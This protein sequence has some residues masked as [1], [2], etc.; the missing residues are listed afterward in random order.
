MQQ[1]EQSVI[2]CQQLIAICAIQLSAGQW[3][4]N[5][6]QWDANFKAVDVVVELLE[7][8]YVPICSNQENARRENAELAQNV[9]GALVLLPRVLLAQRCEIVVL[10]GFEARL[11]PPHADVRE[12]FHDLGVVGDKICAPLRHPKLVELARFE[13]FA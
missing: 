3:S 8:V 5:G 13:L 7:L 10:V 12:P 4:E 9:V 1:I 6:D 11:Q 2:G